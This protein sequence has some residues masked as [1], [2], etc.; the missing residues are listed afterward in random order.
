MQVRPL[1]FSKQNLEDAPRDH[2][3]AYLGLGQI[4]DE[5]SILLRMAMA[6]INSHGE[7][8][9]SRDAA[10]AV[11]LLATRMLA[12]RLAEARDFVNSRPVAVAYR[13]ISVIVDHRYPHFI[14]AMRDAARGRAELFAAIDAE[15]PIRTLRNRSSFHVDPELIDA[16]FAL[17]PADIEL[18]EH[19]AVHRGNSVYGACETLHLT[20]LSH[21]L[22]EPDLGR[23]LERTVDQIGTAVGHLSDFVDGFMLGFTVTHLDPR[24]LGDWIDVPATP[25]DEMRFPLFMSAPAG[26]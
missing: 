16:S 6:G 1:P 19:H 8:Q 11:A 18:M 21:I 25:M 4:A 5:A 15:G 12:G 26:E 20:A 23:A 13:E 2:R 7:L 22:G 17:L 10:N 14:E 3:L 9:P 24:A